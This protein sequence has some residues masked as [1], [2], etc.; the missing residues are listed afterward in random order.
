[1]MESLNIGTDRPA[2]LLKKRPWHR[3]LR[4]SFAKF[5]KTLF[6]QNTSKLLLLKNIS[7]KY[8]NSLIMK[9]KTLFQ[10]F[11]LNIWFL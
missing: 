1:M 6:L 2:A 7:A 9:V 5:L 3:S 4:M 10:T 11:I 8:I